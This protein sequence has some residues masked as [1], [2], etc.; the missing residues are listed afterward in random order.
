LLGEEGRLVL[1]L[2]L[3]E[4]ALLRERAELSG[5]GPPPWPALGRALLLLVVCVALLVLRVAF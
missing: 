5:A 2:E 1:L 3:V 4:L